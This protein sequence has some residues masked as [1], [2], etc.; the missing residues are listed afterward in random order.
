[1]SQTQSS[2]GADRKQVQD[3]GARWV[4]KRREERS[5]ETR[6][7]RTEGPS[8]EWADRAR[9]EAFNLAPIDVD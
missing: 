3:A 8:H 6:P 1:M 4:G 2:V 7:L 5:N 9:V